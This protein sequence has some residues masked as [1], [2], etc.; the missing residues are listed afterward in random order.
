MGRDSNKS[1]SFRRAQVTGRKSCAFIKITKKK[2]F[3]NNRSVYVYLYLYTSARVYRRRH[4]RIFCTRARG[5][6]K[7]K[8]CVRIHFH[9]RVSMILLTSSRH[10][11]FVCHT[12][13][14][15]VYH[16]NTMINL[17]GLRAGRE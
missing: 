12:H 8:P 11:V 10:T 16:I 6:R 13:S 7:T 14:I 9:R 2:T 17:I 4:K 5:T 1:C 15:H 3:Y